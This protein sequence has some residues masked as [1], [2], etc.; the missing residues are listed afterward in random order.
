VREWINDF[1]EA[2]DEDSRFE[3]TSYSSSPYRAL[4][5]REAI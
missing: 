1:F 4:I 3:T 5:P 2:F